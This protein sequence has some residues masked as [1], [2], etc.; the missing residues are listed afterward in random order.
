MRKNGFQWPW[1]PHQICWW[2]LYVLIVFGSVVLLGQLLPMPFNIIFYIVT[3]AGEVAVAVL[4]VMARGVDAAD[5][6]KGTNVSV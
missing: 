1:H 3:A 4:T 2:L 5:D 6:M